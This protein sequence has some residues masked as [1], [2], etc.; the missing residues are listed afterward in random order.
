MER[1][2]LPKMPWNIYWINLDRRPD[3]KEYMEQILVNN[4]ENSVRI[5]AVDYKNMFHPYRV[6]RHPSLN[7]GEHGCVCSHIKALAYFVENSQDEYCFIAEDDISNEYSQYWQQ[8]H[9]DYLTSND[10]EILQLQTTANTFNN[11][12]LTP[13]QK[14]N[15]GTAF[16]R[17]SRKIAIKIIENHY[18]KANLTINLSNNIHP[19]ADNLIWSY[20]DTYLLPMVSYLNVEDSDTSLIPTMDKY[21]SYYFQNAKNKYL[22]MWKN[23]PSQNR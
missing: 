13:Q 2:P 21:W 15:S 9:Y 1:I 6:I 17:I 19:V 11:M 18:D 14:S 4:I 8:R 20:G 23:S 16:Y 10:Y 22:Y 12:D 3:R 5:Q 7:N